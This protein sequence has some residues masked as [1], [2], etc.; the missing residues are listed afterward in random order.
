MPRT[1]GARNTA[2]PPAGDVRFHPGQ[3]C[4]R[5]S[6]WFTGGCDA[7]S[8]GISVATDAHDAGQDPGDGIVKG[9]ADFPDASR[10]GRHISFR[11][12]VFL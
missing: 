2:P 5:A 11:T 7:A 6:E 3:R 8:G 9:Y 1:L 10:L 4:I 12:P